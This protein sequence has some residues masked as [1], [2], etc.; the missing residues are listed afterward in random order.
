MPIQTSPIFTGFRGSVNRNLLFRQCG[1]KTVLSHF[2]D[3]S[4]VVYSELQ[5]QA[6]KR[7]SA[8]V[9]FAR[10]VIREPGL[11]DVYSL[12]ASLLGFRSAW[13]LAIA[14][15]M[16]DKSLEVKP[17]KIRFDKSTLVRSLGWNIPVKLYKFAE[18]SVREVL[19]VPQRIRS[20][21]A[22]PAMHRKQRTR[23]PLKCSEAVLEVSST[24]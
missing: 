10:V 3:R 24:S 8:A 17:K 15:F 13:N 16:S 19:K 18:E 2:P 21:P 12:R 1:G 14:E 22:R 11:R 4:K 6:Q 9:D 7:F 5:K 23:T 20:K